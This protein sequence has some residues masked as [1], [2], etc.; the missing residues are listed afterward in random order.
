MNDLKNTK[1]NIPKSR[2]AGVL[3]LPIDTA[4]SDGTI[5]IGLGFHPNKR[6]EKEDKYVMNHCPNMDVRLT[7]ARK[8]VDSVFWTAMNDFGLYTV[9]FVPVFWMKYEEPIR[10]NSRHES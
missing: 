1:R 8:I 3:W 10:Q 9:G 4:P 7:R 2:S 5:V 6:N